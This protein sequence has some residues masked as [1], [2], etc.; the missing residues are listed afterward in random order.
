ME[1]VTISRGSII[2]P[3]SPM[4]NSVQSFIMENLGPKTK[5]L[6]NYPLPPLPS[7]FILVTSK[8]VPPKTQQ[9]SNCLLVFSILQFLLRKERA[10]RDFLNYVDY[11]DSPNVLQGHKTIEDVLTGTL[12]GKLVGHVRH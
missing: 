2:F 6:I 5:A 10:K 4:N 12:G 8:S 1:L 11:K 7:P 3:L 9:F